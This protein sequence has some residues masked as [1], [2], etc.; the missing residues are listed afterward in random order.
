MK[1]NKQHKMFQ[2]HR[3]CLALL[4]TVALVLTCTGC[5]NLPFTAAGSDRLASE[6]VPDVGTS[7]QMWHTFPFTVEQA[8][9][10]FFG[11]EPCE[12]IGA[13]CGYQ[14][15][16]L[17]SSRPTA[18][19]YFREEFSGSDYRL[20]YGGSKTED[21]VG[22]TRHT[23]MMT[24]LFHHRAY[25]LQNGRPHY[26][27]PSCD[28]AFAPE[29][30]ALL[31]LITNHP[32]NDAVYDHTRA[33]SAA[34]LQALGYTDAK[35]IFSSK[36]DLRA[37]RMLGRAQ[38]VP[39]AADAAPPPY[40]VVRY[41]LQSASVPSA[42]ADALR[43]NHM[44]T[45]TF[46][47]NSDGNLVR[48]SITTVPEYEVTES[49]KVRY[50]AEQA[51][52]LLPDSWNRKDCVLVDAY[53][54]PYRAEIGKTSYE[55][56]WTFRFLAPPELSHVS[57]MQLG[58]ALEVLGIAGRYM[59]MQCHVNICTGEVSGGEWQYSSHLIHEYNG[60]HMLLK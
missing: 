13:F 59:E 49:A 53:L 22:G 19:W 50:T 21:V 39:L 15:L 2:I 14:T 5:S 28:I 48:A 26:D 1:Y 10:V 56:C 16:S 30:G 58:S 43:T 6:P 12:P 18:S 29:S 8:N 23:R 32:D 4:L 51:F 46:T 27:P 35:E 34:K 57:N 60:L 55:E 17:G 54:E 37:M 52:A 9:E 45:A 33:D 40:Y 36:I 38:G 3:Q 47:Y 41:S 7:G 25:A 20:E 24:F 42:W 31:E 44:A 11:D